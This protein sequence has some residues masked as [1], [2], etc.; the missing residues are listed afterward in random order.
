MRSNVWFTTQPVEEPEPRAHL[1]DAIEWMGWDRVLFAT[2]YPHWDFDDPVHALPI[3]M[4]EQQKRG[5]FRENARAVYGF[6]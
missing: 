5:I 3:R 6:A 2:D 4:T 1:A